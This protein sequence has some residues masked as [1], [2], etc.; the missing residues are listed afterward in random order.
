MLSAPGGGA[1][2]P[3]KNRNFKII[4]RARNQSRRDWRTQR[5]GNANATHKSRGRG[6][7]P[8]WCAFRIQVGHR[9]RSEKCQKPAG[10]TECV[11][12]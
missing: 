10:C 8:L 4:H 5:V 2:D 3:L 1:A 9:A 6:E 7:R 12:L 11:G